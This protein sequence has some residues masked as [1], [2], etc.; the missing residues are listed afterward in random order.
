MNSDG[1]PLIIHPNS[2]IPINRIMSVYDRNLNPGD[3]PAFNASMARIMLFDRWGAL[4]QGDIKDCINDKYSNGVR[5]YPNGIPNGALLWDAYGQNHSSIVQDD[6]YH[7]F[8]LATNCTY[9]TEQVITRWT[10]IN[11]V[12]FLGFVI[13]TYT[14]IEP[15]LFIH[16]EN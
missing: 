9:K 12:K 16:V 13:W 7:W 5:K 11:E 6:V 15:V 3:V 14:T 1:T 4:W 2:P 10:I 8:A